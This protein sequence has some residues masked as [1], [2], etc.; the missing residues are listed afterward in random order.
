MTNS[1][2]IR[3][4]A[5]LQSWAADAVS[6]NFVKTQ[7]Y[8]TQ[9]GLQGLVA[10]ALGCRRGEW[11]EWIQGMH[12]TVREDKSPSITNEYQTIG[13]REDEFDFRRRIAT[14]LQL[15]GRLT[16]VS[17]LA[18]KPGTQANAISRRTLLADGEFLVRITHETHTEEIDQALASPKFSTY[19]GKKAF[20]ATFPF[21]LGVGNSELINSIPVVNTRESGPK[22]SVILR[23]IS[24]GPGATPETLWVPRVGN[25]S[26]WLEGVQVLGL[27]RRRTIAA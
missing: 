9:S 4:S 15:K 3:L 16:T 13:S 20:P 7:R 23:E 5:P 11:P 12:F 19:L 18:F 26:E 6:G 21:Y 1:V 17:S 10:G 24:L 22:A 2:F 25:R 8:P 27:Q 14:S